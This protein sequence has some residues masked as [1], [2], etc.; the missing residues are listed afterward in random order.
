M[1][2]RYL[3]L[4]LLLLVVVASPLVVAAQP[5]GSTTQPIDVVIVLDD[6][7][8]MAISNQCGLQSKPPASDPNDLRYSAARL[9][10]QL[11]E[12][13]DRIAV[14][15][16][17]AKADDV[18]D[19]GSLQTIEGPEN[20]QRLIGG[21]EAPTDYTGRCYTR[22]DLGL[23][24]ASE[25]LA[26]S[27][28]QGRNQYILFLT[29]GRPTQQ[30]GTAEQKNT[31]PPIIADLNK[32]QIDV[33]P[34]LLCSPGSR[35]TSEAD[36]RAASDISTIM[37]R[38]PVKAHT[39]SNLLQVFSSLFAQMKPNL[40]VVDETNRDGDIELH[41][42]DAHA[43]RQINVISGEGGLTALRRDN[44]NVTTQQALQDGN[45]EV[46]VVESSA[47][48]TGKWT[49][50]S[51]AGS[52]VV[53]RTDTYP[54]VVHPPATSGNAPRFVPQGK[55]ALV[56]GTVI[57]PGGGEEL[58]K[59]GTPL[60]ALTSDGRLRFI[61]M[62]G[63]PDAIT[64]QVGN[65]T[66]PLQIKRDFQIA[67]RANLPQAQAATPECA[68]QT[69]CLLEVALAPGPEI[70]SLAA[71]VYVL[72]ESDKARPVY[73]NEMVCTERQCA[74]SGF[75]PV[76][77]HSYR[78]LFTVQGVAQN[79]LYGDWDETSVIMEPAVAV[80]G[81][82]DPL[83]PINQPNDGWPVK[84]IAG[85][86]EDLG[87]L[88]AR[89]SVTRLADGAPLEGVDVQFSADI[90][91][92]G[93][94]Q[95]TLAITL[96][97]DMRPGRYEGELTFYTDRE[98]GDV[99]LPPVH[100]IAFNLGTPRVEVLET[101][102]DFGKQTFDPSPNFRVDL[103]QS[104][105]L[106]F[107]DRSFPLTAEL[108][109]GA[110]CENLA[111]DVTN[112]EASG[113]ETLATLRVWSQE[114][115]KP[116][117]CSGQL[118]LTGPGEDFKVENGDRINWRFEIPA[119]E[120]KL[121]GVENAD[122]SIAPDLS[123]ADMGRAT[124]RQML[125][126]L[127]E[128][129]GAPN[130]QM[131]AEPV[132]ATGRDRILGSE[133]LEVLVGRPESHSS[134]ASTYRVPVE[135]VAKTD[136][137]NSGLRGTVYNG[138]IRFYVLGLPEESAQETSFR[139]LSPSW[140]Q[141]HVFPYYRLPW[142]GIP[143]WCS[144]WLAVLLL[145]FVMLRWRASR[146]ERRLPPPPP[147]PPVPP[148]P[149]S[150]PNDPIGDDDWVPFSEGAS[151][152]GSSSGSGTSGSSWGADSGIFGPAFNDT[153]PV[154]SAPSASLAGPFGATNAS[155]D[156]W[157]FRATS[158]EPSTYSASGFTGQDPTTLDDSWSPAQT[159]ALPWL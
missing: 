40:H 92:A 21:I 146:I 49:V 55:A 77:G 158:G 24:R 43:A 14:V 7:E 59:D 144:T 96:P 89:A 29:D 9:L 122:G 45:I 73:S 98:S 119:L 128:Y 82:P 22:M 159:S 117:V 137:A 60:N 124:E 154:S 131:Q 79:T 152:F 135:L 52:F 5:T 25:I 74:D 2:R 15:R 150:N 93:E 104:L 26:A 115:L 121:I 31:V 130:F 140:L 108:L 76:D 134:L 86:T 113:D 80:R 100:T 141:R 72:D 148:P 38:A 20:R 57:G 142:P 87:R 106:R 156:N 6:S 44:S 107:G 143:S 94:Q 97:E 103:S 66:V 48:P 56:V 18:G 110:T 42:R 149:P 3:L 67:T 101:S 157:V 61:E 132:G 95:T 109:P 41:T 139:F 91:G 114:P 133:A 64:L 129:T 16:F 145:L 136:I 153:A 39:A 151:L 112:I 36:L 35:C 99:R 63:S 46:N 120:W 71:Q 155:S 50:D 116:G 78:V 47:L 126:L 1:E 81:L 127:V 68:P 11:A 138:L 88:R 23:Q 54:D 90:R 28:A 32:R 147:P 30:T 19:L 85:T 27:P 123:F 83:N 118:R 65:D 102:L 69:A 62:S 4:A 51:T 34:V 53:A 75:V 8:S 70:A 111:A 17:D 12:S 13:D 10:V 84:V 125:M 105:R 37:G 33:M 58:Y